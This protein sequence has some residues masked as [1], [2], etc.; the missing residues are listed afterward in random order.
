[1][2]ETIM[3]PPIKTLPRAR[4]NGAPARTGKQARLARAHPDPLE[5]PAE[6]MPFPGANITNNVAQFAGAVAHELRQPLSTIQLIA[7]HLKTGFRKSSVAPET[8]AML[9]EQA[10]LAGEILGSLVAFA[11]SGKARKQDANL[12]LI[13]R[14]VLRR[15]S[16]PLE[17]TLIQNL[18]RRLPTACAEPIHVDRIISNLV[19]NALESMN[20]G[21][22]LSITTRTKGNEVILRI[23]DTGCGV[24]AEQRETLFRPF[25][26]TK[27]NGMG[28]GLALCCQL[29]RSNGGSIGLTS[30]EGKGTVFELRLPRAGIAK[31]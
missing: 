10:Q 9:E 26:T 19:K 27:T 3:S 6:D 14:G 5:V 30:R 8:L 13:L 16:L 29:A 7:S 11:K 20:G 18:S 17:I 12:H 23:A 21:G 15:T 28:L 4:R 22:T 31:D 25:A 2:A 1:M 24:S